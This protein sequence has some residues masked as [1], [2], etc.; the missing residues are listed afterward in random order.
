MPNFHYRAATQATS[1]KAEHF[2]MVFRRNDV[3][4]FNELVQMVQAGPRT[5]N[6]R[7][8]WDYLLIG[9]KN[10]GLFN[11]N[12]PSWYLL[13]THSTGVYGANSYLYPGVAVDSVPNY[14][15]QYIAMDATSSEPEQRLSANF[16]SENI[17]VVN[18]VEQ[19]AGTD[20][21]PVIL[22]F[23]F[24]PAVIGGPA[25]NWGRQLSS[26]TDDRYICRLYFD[27]WKTYLYFSAS[28]YAS[29]A[30]RY[31]YLR[32][33]NQTG[34]LIWHRRLDSGLTSLAY[35]VVGQIAGYDSGNVDFAFVVGESYQLPQKVYVQKYLADGSYGGDPSLIWESPAS[36]GDGGFTD[37]PSYL[38]SSRPG[39]DRTFLATRY[40]NFAGTVN[41]AIFVANSNTALVG[42]RITET[43]EPLIPLGCVEDG[44]VGQ[45]IFLMGKYEN[46][47]ITS[48]Y[49]IKINPL[50]DVVWQRRIWFTARY[51][52]ESLGGGPVEASVEI[53]NARI[54][55]SFDDE[56]T[57]GRDAYAI[58]VDLENLTGFGGDTQAPQVQII[59]SLPMNGQLRTDHFLPFENFSAGTN[60]DLVMRVVYEESNLVFT[61]SVEVTDQVGSGFSSATTN[62]FTET[63]ASFSRTDYQIY[64]EADQGLIR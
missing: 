61:P 28:D 34:T 38:V 36:S 26:G 25:F 63:S 50:A 42:Y 56:T 8:N 13:A 4:T 48:L 62:P 40:Y 43:D 12:C 24:S 58:A 6:G 2:Y 31:I 53:K 52:D 54:S 39:W 15:S 17:Y 3:T 60:P 45:C 49:A 10:G 32:K 29:S 20:Y 51:N 5:F 14:N 11:V 22:S 64:V 7:K 27:N 37:A 35:Q 46:F 21:A 30:R 23:D 1:G 47:S 57:S 16:Q 33:Y 41:K 44:G 55:K 19:S 59:M 9:Q 18:A